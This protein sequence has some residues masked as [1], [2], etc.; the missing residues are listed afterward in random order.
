MRHLL[1]ILLTTTSIFGFGQ[2]KDSMYQTNNEQYHFNYAKILKQ[3]GKP[4]LALLSISEA[5]DYNNSDPNILYMA[6]VIYN[7]L[8]KKDDALLFEKLALVSFEKGHYFKLSPYYLYFD[9]GVSNLL[10]QKYQLAYYCFNE[11]LRYRATAIGAFNRGSCKL[12]LENIEGAC[13]D[14]KIA[15]YN[16]IT[17]ADK[18]IDIYCS[19]ST[20]DSLVYTLR[21]DST[22]FIDNYAPGK[23][24]MTVA[25]Y[26]NR[27]W[28]ITH[29]RSKYYRISGW[30]VSQQ[31]FDGPFND[32][33]KTNKIAEGTY[34]NG[35]LNGMYHSFYE[36]GKIQSAGFFI[37]GKPIGKWLFFHY[38]GNP[39]LSVTFDNDHFEVHQCQD[40]NG[41]FTLKDGNGNW[42]YRSM[43]GY[44]CKGQYNKYKRSGI[45]S[46]T[47][48][49]SSYNYVE[50]YNQQ[51]LF[52]E[53]GITKKT[54]NYQPQPKPDFI[55]N[56]IDVRNDRINDFYL[57][58][59]KVLDKYSFLHFETFTNQ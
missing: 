47:R 45:W 1:I 26:Y 56:L 19:E 53:S 46:I 17:E 20:D 36:N 41:N 18:L 29:E 49:A 15:K 10:K 58:S 16:G 32:Y 31:K 13:N 3:E 59:E 24:T 52:K 28:Y 30:I 4:E 8:G 23:D 37:D 11:A 5:L 2:K 25:I 55:N 21:N 39:W 14:W 40:I 6:S 38:N 35:K 57:E 22:T 12:Y 27:E 9:Y 48:G 54:K 51:G 50:E 33:L 34:N 7:E 42:W 43:L 44:T